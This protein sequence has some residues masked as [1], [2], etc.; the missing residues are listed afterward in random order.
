MGEH[1]SIEKIYLP[2]II[3]DKEAR[4]REQDGA[5]QIPA[6]VSPERDLV[7]QRK[8]PAQGKNKESFGIKIHNLNSLKKNSDS[9]VQMSSDLKVSEFLASQSNTRNDNSF[10]EQSRESKKQND[11]TSF[12]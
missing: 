3:R 1:E 5:K 4:E 8:K 9:G 6:E 11:S 7:Q 2:Q 12:S 10:V